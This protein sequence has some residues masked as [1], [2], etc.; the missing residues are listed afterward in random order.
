MKSM[1]LNNTYSLKFNGTLTVF[2]GRNISH[3]GSSNSRPTDPK[4]VEMISTNSQNKLLRLVKGILTLPS[5]VT[6]S[7]GSAY[8]GHSTI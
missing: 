8:W 4:I 5:L 1:S 7:M 3:M 2:L 6:T